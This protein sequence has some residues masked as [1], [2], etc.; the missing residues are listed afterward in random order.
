MGKNYTIDKDF[1]K[2]YEKGERISLDV[3]PPASDG[4]DEA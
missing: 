3:S 1:E 4:G 2:E